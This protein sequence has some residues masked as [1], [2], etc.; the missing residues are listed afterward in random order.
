M[1][2]IVARALMLL[3]AAVVLLA[4]GMLLP[5]SRTPNGGR[6]ILNVL[7]VVAALILGVFV[8]LMVLLAGP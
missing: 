1:V 3:A 2:P 4:L 6:P 5:P 8:F 7:L